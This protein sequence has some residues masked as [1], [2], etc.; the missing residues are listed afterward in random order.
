M[1]ILDNQT[2]MKKKLFSSWEQ[3]FCWSKLARIPQDTGFWI[4]CEWLHYEKKKKE[5]V[6]K[7]IIHFL[8]IAYSLY[9]LRQFQ[10]HGLCLLKDTFWKFL[11]LFVTFACQDISCL[12]WTA[13]VKYSKLTLSLTL[14]KHCVNYPVVL[15]LLCANVFRQYIKH[16]YILTPQNSI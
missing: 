9:I 14:S 8:C 4:M 13:L 12:T 1:A 6:I 15:C 7:F 11:F 3:K 10:D 2:I 16:A 5:W